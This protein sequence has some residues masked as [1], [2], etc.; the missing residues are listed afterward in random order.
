MRMLT[1][2]AGWGPKTAKRGDH[3]TVEGFPAKDGSH[4]MNLGMI[5]LPN[6]QSLMG[7]P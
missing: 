2:F 6:G 7:A 4:Y 3:V 5:V 1:R